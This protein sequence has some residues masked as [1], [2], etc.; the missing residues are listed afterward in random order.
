MAT[1]GQLPHFP[2][3]QVDEEPTSLASRWQKWL[4]RFENFL[5]AMAISDDGR[6]RAMLLHY[7]GERV[8]DIFDS[9]PLSEVGSSYT[10]ATTALTSYFNPQKNEDF[11]VWTFRQTIQEPGETLDAYH[12]R[13]RQ[14]SKYCG[15]PD[16]RLDKEIKAQIIHG[17]T[18]RRLRRR[19]LRD[20]TMSLTELLSFGR[21][22]ESSDRQAANIEERHP[23]P[24]QP[25]VHKL[26]HHPQRKTFPPKTQRRDSNRQPSSQQPR[27]APAPKPRNRECFNCGGQWPHEGGQ[28]N[29]PARNKQCNA[30]SKLNHFASVCRSK[31]ANH[32]QDM[33]QDEANHQSH[34]NSDTDTSDEECTYTLSAN[35]CSGAAQKRPMTTI[36][37]GE[38][39]LHVL[40]DSGASVNIMGTQT[41]DTLRPRP[42]LSKT[43]TKVFPYGSTVALP[44]A[45]KFEST[46][47]SKTKF[48]GATFY[49][50][51]GNGAPLISYQ[52]ASELGLIHVVDANIQGDTYKANIMA[53][54]PKLFSDKV[55][56]LKGV[57]VKIHVDKSVS[58]VA[59]PHRRIP[60]HVRKK[61]EAELK[62]LEDEDIIE[63][64]SGGTP[65]VSPIVVAPKRDPNAIRLCVDMRAANHAIIRERHPMPT[66]DDVINDLNGSTV[67]SK[68]D[69][70]NAYHTLELEPESR[71]ITT[72]STHVGLFRYKR[73]N[74]GICSAS[75]LFSHT[76]Q[77]LLQ[78][79]P[80]VISLSDDILVHG[81]DQQSHDASLTLV[82]QRLEDNGL[83]VNAPKCEFNQPRLN[84]YGYV[85]SKNGISPDPQKI[86]AIQTLTP[87]TTKAEV[88]SFLGMINYS[89]RFIKDYATLAAPLRE[90][91]K[92]NVPWQWKEKHENS[93]KTL[94]NSLSSK[95]VMAYF[96]QNKHTELVVD[97]SP[98][99]LGAILAQRQA[100]GTSP[101]V[102]AYASRA[103]TDVEM[104][105]S[106][107]EREAL[108]IVW[109]C[110]HFDLYLLGGKFDLISDHKPLEMIFN[111]PKSKPPA[112]IERWA[113]RLQQY[114]FCVRYAPGHSNP[115]DYPS[116]CP[117]PSQRPCKASRRAEEYVNFVAESAVPKA[118]T[119]EDIKAAMDTDPTLQA[120]KDMVK[121]EHW[122]QPPSK[123]LTPYYHVRTELSLTNDQRILL[124]GNR[125]VIPESL[126]QQ[127][128]QLAHEGHQGIGKSKSLM[129]E[130]VWFPEMDRRIEAMVRNCIAC[131]ACTDQKRIEPLHMSPLPNHPWDHV[132][133]DFCGPFPSGEYILV[134]ICEYSR[135]PVVEIIKSTAANTVIPVLDKIFSMFSIPTQ[136]KTDG[137]SPFNSRDFKIFAEYLG[138]QHRKI[139]PYW[140]RSNAE[141]E[142]FMKTMQKAIRAAIIENKPW[143]RELHKFLR[144]YRATPHSSTKFAP[145]ELLFQRK[146][147]TRI[148]QIT[149][150]SHATD[151]AVRENDST[152]KTSIKTYGDHNLHTKQAHFTPG[153]RVLVRKPKQTKLSPPF[154]PSP[155][156]IQKVKGSMITA[157]RADHQITRNSSYFKLLP[158]ASGMPRGTGSTP[159]AADSDDDLD[160]FI[161]QPRDPAVPTEVNNAPTNDPGQQ[162]D[163]PGQQQGA[164]EPP[165]QTA[166]KRYPSRDRRPPDYYV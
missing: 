41:Y 84:F 11:E 148:P 123:E 87:P 163:N 133:M 42:N 111:N 109:A 90:L 91:T 99:G 95:H 113:L 128:L 16:D 136:V 131:Q 103:L 75:E 64:V 114:D 79:I 35:A 4:K 137:G 12:T 78:D 68:V 158:P 118:L 115:A 141:A 43:T 105:Y 69:I 76:I 22:L 108:A 100:A 13:A 63:R 19:A 150:K 119:L 88:R 23:A 26:N 104:R 116:R 52:T 61:V 73:L 156:T 77:Q 120:V 164:A 66:V 8:Y 28:T 3:F 134:V 51:K 36:T 30:C 149:C 162:P 1:G 165:P 71:S 5:S 6:K 138:F 38:S 65:W 81:V 40:I 62:R 166:R 157:E 83:T 37:I 124:R 94:V 70:R 98:V 82:C 125:I 146:P 49:V 97:A 67:F 45:G 147:N 154:D 132:S 110:E 145:A 96:D 25:Q 55:G 161:D 92:Q 60:Y 56:K 50:L 24:T 9:L 160:D 48:T 72:F 15:F 74:F 152:A 21:A 39:R 102:V 57:Q 101:A 140:P 135:Y 106:Q 112:R 27:P 151:K 46:V 10:D 59:Q 80:G 143:Q 117:L 142:R 159:A 127:A 47:E 34:P 31:Q 20:N 2:P 121:S 54:H 14:A 144:N 107:T 155:Y 33:P 44:I 32:L 58:P 7:A 18:S 129:R 153:D 122:P 126:K 17:C 29:C 86:T 53:K 139:T 89:S 130:K 85:F 93:F